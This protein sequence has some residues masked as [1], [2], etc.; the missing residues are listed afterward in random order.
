MIH[1][2]YFGDQKKISFQKHVT[3][4]FKENSFDACLNLPTLVKSSLGKQVSRKFRIEE[5]MKRGE[6]D[7]GLNIINGGQI[8]YSLFKIVTS[9]WAFSF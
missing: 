1:L 4:K 5:I 6:E 7:A 9:I 3:H 2:F 8:K